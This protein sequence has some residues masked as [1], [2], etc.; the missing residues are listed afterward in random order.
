M[1]TRDKKVNRSV[2]IR[3]GVHFVPIFSILFFSPPPPPL[4]FLFLQFHVDL[5]WVLTNLTKCRSSATLQFDGWLRS[6]QCRHFAFRLDRNDRL[7]H[8]LDTI[9]SATIQR[10]YTLPFRDFAFILVFQYWNTAFHLYW[11]AA[12][13]RKYYKAAVF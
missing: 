5:V 7:R 12:R 8:R 4:S 3:C 10:P 9:N 13:R 11:M 6:F 1:A 2:E